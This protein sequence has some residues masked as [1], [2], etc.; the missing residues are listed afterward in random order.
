MQGLFFC[1]SVRRYETSCLRRMTD[2]LGVA[3][4]ACWRRGVPGFQTASTWLS[5]GCSSAVGPVGRACHWACSS[6][7]PKAPSEALTAWP[8]PNALA[9]SA[10]LCTNMGI[11]CSRPCSDRCICRSWNSLR[12]F[13]PTRTS[14]RGG[15]AR[16]SAPTMTFLPNGSPT[17]WEATCWKWTRRNSAAGTPSQPQVFLRR[18]RTLRGELDV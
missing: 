10:S 15:A 2:T 17:T 14:H 7:S 6:S 3:P 9:C 11:P 1:W 5:T 13:G 18:K 16:K 4:D 12:R 8:T